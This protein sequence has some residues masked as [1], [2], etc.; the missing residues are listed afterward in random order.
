MTQIS[1]LVSA[2]S[3]SARAIRRSLVISRQLVSHA[4]RQYPARCAFYMSRSTPLSMSDL[5]CRSIEAAS[6]GSSTRMPAS[7]LLWSAR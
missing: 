3:F 5:M 6:S 2:S 1:Y 4:L 7:R